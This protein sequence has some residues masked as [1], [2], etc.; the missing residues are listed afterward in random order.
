MTE[1]ARPVVHAR[2]ARAKLNYA[3]HVTGQRA[4]GY[5]LVDS[6]VV[7]PAIGDRVGL[8]PAATV[9]GL[10]LSGRFAG[11]LGHSNGGDNL[12]V[13]AARRLAHHLGRDA[14]AALALKKALPV[15]S[16]IGGGSADAAATMRL[17]RD[18]WAPELD[19]ETLA[20]LAGDLGAD[21]PMCLLSKPAR[22][23]G[24]GEIVTPLLAF[25]AHAVVLA[26]PGVAV[27]T[28]DVFTALKTKTNK[29][30]PA[31]PQDGFRDLPAL[32]AWLNRTRN[33]LEAPARALAPGIGDT[34]D[35]LARCPGV[36]QVR[37]SGS[38]ATCFALLET[39][40][41][42]Q[43]AARALNDAHPGWWVAAAPVERVGPP[44]G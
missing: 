10:S 32:C 19:D 30:L 7:F 44:A 14:D 31:I 3:L 37:M 29:P 12:V 15:A 6:L 17:L 1:T 18:L 38:G 39:V 4:D 34:L 24:I 41:A 33:D 40:D 20:D 28:P 23:E 8:D 2:L 43:E 26:N 35:A 42:A 22:V 9:P 27:S 16:G 13:K 36:E 11:D 25:P 21:V 5:H